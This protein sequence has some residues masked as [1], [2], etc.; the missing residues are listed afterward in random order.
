M[1]TVP[2]EMWRENRS[3]RRFGKEKLWLSFGTYSAGRRRGAGG[4]SGY[5]GQS[6]DARVEATGSIR[7]MI[8]P[9]ITEASPN[10]S[11]N[12]LKRTPQSYTSLKL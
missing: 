10:S 6:R 2:C 9:L 12:Y 11:L 4:R 7:V 1:V 3:P 8:S 5:W